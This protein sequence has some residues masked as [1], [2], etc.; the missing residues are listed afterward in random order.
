MS[1]SD[2][3]PFAVKLQDCQLP[4]VGLGTFQSED[5]NDKVKEAVNSALR[6]GYRHIDTAFA[7][8]NEAQVGEAIRESGIAREDVFLTTK[9]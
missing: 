7:Y 4:V 5:G 8:G 2:V 1:R 9:L 3:L 6:A